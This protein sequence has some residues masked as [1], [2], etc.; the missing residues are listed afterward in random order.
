MSDS[1]LIVDQLSR[2]F[3]G[4]AWHGP[5]VL[6]LLAN[7]DARTAAN[8]PIAK[9]H[10]IWELLLHIEAW[11][12]AALRRFAGE[13]VELKDEE[14]FPPISDSSDAAW[15]AT[16]MKLKRTHE[17]LLT[18]ITAM[19][20]S[21]LTQQVPGKDYDFEFMFH[22]LAQHALYHAGQIAILKIAAA[23]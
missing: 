12:L 19:S 22:G 23:K 21:H 9:A 4:E 13:M 3:D 5:S 18:T 8:R 7:V 11:E 17:Q 15:K 16:L 6:E 1:A 14:D 10:S 2:A 20:R